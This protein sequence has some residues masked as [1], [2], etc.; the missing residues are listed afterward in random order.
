MVVL[1]WRVKKA[2]VKL[3]DVQ[4][5]IVSKIEDNYDSFKSN[6]FGYMKIDLIFWIKYNLI[7]LSQLFFAY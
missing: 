6:W 2:N 3:H 1:G 5:L 7:K 4:W